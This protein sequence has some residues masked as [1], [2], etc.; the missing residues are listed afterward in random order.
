V[1]PLPP[2]HGREPAPV[3]PLA[4]VTAAQA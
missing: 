2:G 3:P 4:S 1:S